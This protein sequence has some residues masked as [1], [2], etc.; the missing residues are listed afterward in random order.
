MVEKYC[1]SLNNWGEPNTPKVVS[2]VSYRKM[3]FV[4]IMSISRDSI[5]VNKIR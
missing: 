3:S 2:L 5:I 1:R 4:Y